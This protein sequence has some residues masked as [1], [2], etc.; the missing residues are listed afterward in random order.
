MLLFLLI[1]AIVFSCGESSTGGGSPLTPEEEPTDQEI[2]KLGSWVI[3]ESIKDLYN[4]YI[5]EKPG[6]VINLRDKLCPE[7]GTVSV[8]GTATNIGPSQGTS[9]ALAYSFNNCKCK[10]ESMGTVTFIDGDIQAFGIVGGDNQ[11]VSCVGTSNIYLED[12]FVPLKMDTY[13]RL[14]ENA[15]IA[16]NVAHSEMTGTIAGNDVSGGNGDDD[17]GN[18]NGENGL[19]TQCWTLINAAGDVAYVVVK[20]FTYSGTFIESA[21][22]PGWWL[23]DGEGKAVARVPVSGS[24]SHA[25]QY[26]TWDFT[27]TVQGGGMQITGQGT[28]RTTDGVYPNARNVSGSITGTLVIPN[29]YSGPISDNWTG[30]YNSTCP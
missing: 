6:G 1:I 30:Y 25:G 19:Q 17:N 21:N 2:L 7:G 15:S 23:Y 18:G 26:D 5:A 14:F 12:V 8:N 13:S 20:P 3:T 22:S 10:Q 9:I 16:V 28:G 27:I 11:S 4:T 29:V 24:I